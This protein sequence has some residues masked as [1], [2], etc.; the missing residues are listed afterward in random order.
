MLNNKI[1]VG[2]RGPGKKSMPHIHHPHDNVVPHG[3]NNNMRLLEEILNGR[4]LITRIYST[5]CITVGTSRT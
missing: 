4:V 3:K 2:T 5:P 1:S